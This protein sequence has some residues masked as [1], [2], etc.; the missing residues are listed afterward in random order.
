MR[1]KQRMG[2]S[3]RNATF[4]PT[5][6]LIPIKIREAGAPVAVSVGCFM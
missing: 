3:P 1:P 5:N 2:R 6:F 4:V